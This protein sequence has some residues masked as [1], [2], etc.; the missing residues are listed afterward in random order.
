MD[1]RKHA[2]NNST[3]EKIFQAKEALRSDCDGDAWAMLLAFRLGAATVNLCG[4]AMIAFFLPFVRSINNQTANH[5]N[6]GPSGP[7]PKHRSESQN[8]DILIA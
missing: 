1:A 4:D 6:I 5:Q 3:H 2:D 8:P 7:E